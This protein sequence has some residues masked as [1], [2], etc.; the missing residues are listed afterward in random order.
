VRFALCGR[1]K[2][3]SPLILSTALAVREAG[4]V[5][6]G[7]LTPEIMREFNRLVGA[8]LEIVQAHL[9]TAEQKYISRAE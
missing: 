9:S 4:D 7:Q 6:G 1:S 3:T 8:E 2:N 5:Q